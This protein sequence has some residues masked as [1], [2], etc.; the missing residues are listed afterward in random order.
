MNEV[1]FYVLV[2]ISGPT[3][4]PGTELSPSKIEDDMNNMGGIDKAQCEQSARSIA[5][6]MFERYGDKYGYKCRL[7]TYDPPNLDK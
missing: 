4:T 5:Q 6:I 3:C 1:W 7:S 2:C